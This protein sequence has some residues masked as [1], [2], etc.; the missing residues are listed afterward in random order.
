MNT[1]G[2]EVFV[3]TTIC[4]MLQRLKDAGTKIH[5]YVDGLCA[6]A[7]T[8]ILMM[9]D[10]I[11]IYENSVVMIHKPI[12]CCYGNALDFQK[13]IDVL[14][15]IENSTM[16]PLYMKKAKVDEEKVKELINAESW[17]GAEET[18]KTFDVNLIK[19]QKQVAA[20]AS[21]LFKKY[22]NVPK[23]LRNVTEKPKFDYSDFE[24]RLFSIKK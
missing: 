10:D 17:L 23:Q 20:C 13:G 21:E 19:E 22:K 2:G 7:G 9:G 6:S 3:A 24:K 18:D 12:S 16:I 11:N 4:S 14:N 5:T 1:P 15:T 8:F